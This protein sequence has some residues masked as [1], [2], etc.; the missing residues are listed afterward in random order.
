MREPLLEKLAA[1]LRRVRETAHLMV[2]QPDYQRYLAHTLAHHP[3][4]QP[5]SH[6]EF[7]R[8]AMDRRYGKGTGRCC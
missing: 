4:R 2:G 7:V 1:G 6:T 8:A 5:L 3:E